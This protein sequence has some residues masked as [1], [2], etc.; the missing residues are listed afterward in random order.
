LEPAAKL[1]VAEPMVAE[2][3][4]LPS[5]VVDMV[6]QASAAALAIDQDNRVATINPAAI[7]LLGADG[8][9]A[10]GAA[11]SSILRA[12]D[13]YGNRIC[14]DACALHSMARSSEAVQSFELE[15]ESG[16]KPLRVA[17]SVVVVLSPWAEQYHLV[18]YLRP[19]LRRRKADEAIERLVN[20][21]GGAPLQI[22]GEVANGVELP[23]LTARQT[24]ILCRIAGGGATRDIADDLHISV[25]TVRNHTQNILRKLSV[26]SKTEAVSLA[27]RQ[28]LI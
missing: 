17:V 9:R 23:E 8:E 27:I 15:L 13:V 16:D 20:G 6:E 11:L 10:V 28:R 25:N 21:D 4:A 1:R 5:R 3:M 12:R 7:E 24:E 19:R 14:D 22:L 18:Y 2:P 26:H